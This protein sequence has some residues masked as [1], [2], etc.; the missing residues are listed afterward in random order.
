M[1]EEIH[2]N[3]VREPDQ[4]GVQIDPDSC[5]VMDGHQHPATNISELADSI[6]ALGQLHHALVIEYA[7]GRRFIAAGRRRWMA[8]KSLGRPLKADIWLCNEEDINLELFARA[9]RVAENLQRCEPSSMDVAIQLLATRNERGF[10]NARELAESMGMS[11]SSVKSYLSVFRASDHL[12]DM[13]KQYALPL[14]Q[15]L[16]LTKCEKQLGVARTRKLIE[17]V[18]KGELAHRDLAKLRNK[19]ERKP[20]SE[21]AAAL[22]R[23]RKISHA[24]LRK[25]GNVLLQALAE[26]PSGYQAYVEE[27]MVELAR[28]L[29][30]AEET[31]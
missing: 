11:E 6:A 29:P 20:A 30:A 21:Q 7:D 2:A 17:R 22:P 19:P 15:V 12:Q 10:K 1:K 27:L 25:S 28:F 31:T 8:C 14:V 13:A 5:E 3:A 9:V 24:F 26:G 16:E 4:V 23:K 18:T